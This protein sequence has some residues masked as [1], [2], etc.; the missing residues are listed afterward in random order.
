MKAPG[1]Y[2]FLIF[3]GAVKSRKLRK[4][5]KMDCALPLE[6]TPVKVDV[7]G[8]FTK[9][10]LNTPP[11]Q[12][13]PIRPKPALKLSG[14]GLKTREDEFNELSKNKE[15]LA[16]LD[17]NLDVRN[18]NRQVLKLGQFSDVCSE[19]YPNIYVGGVSVAKNY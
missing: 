2:E 1:V 13:S 17:L 12:K 10:F 7:F 15:N 6:I 5:R 4:V 8:L 9:H 16:N 18:T 19:V 14:I 3:G 11:E